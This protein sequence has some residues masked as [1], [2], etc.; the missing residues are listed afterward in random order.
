MS[1]N[2]YSSIIEIMQKQGSKFNPPSIKIATVVFVEETD[3]EVLDI[4][5]RVDGLEIDKDNIYI[6][7]YLLKEHKREIRTDP[8]NTIPSKKHMSGVT[9]IVNDHG[10]N[11]QDHDHVLTDLTIHHTNIYTRDTLSKGDLV[12]VM[13]VKDKQ[14][15]II[16]SRVVRIGE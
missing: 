7:D 3:T 16:L 14:T 9:S 5:I 15:Y 13:P 1:E 8:M 12:A 4:K 10:H 6:S 11:A 2:P